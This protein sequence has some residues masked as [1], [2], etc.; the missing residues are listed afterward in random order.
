MVLSYNNML[1]FQNKL[2][3][4]DDFGHSETVLAKKEYLTSLVARVPF[5]FHGMCLAVELVVTLHQRNR[6]L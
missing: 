4:P 5:Q 1:M 6:T 3:I 2:A